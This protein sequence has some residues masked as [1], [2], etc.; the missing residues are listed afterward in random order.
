MKLCSSFGANLILHNK[1]EMNLSS[2]PGVISRET[3]QA[4]M[5][6]KPLDKKM[7]QPTTESMNIMTKKDQNGHH[8]EKNNV[9]RKT[10]VLG[11]RP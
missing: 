1:D 4:I 2:A 9:G 11:A 6:K 3:V 5:T 7:G 10:R 8:H